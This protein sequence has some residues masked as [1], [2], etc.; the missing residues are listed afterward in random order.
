[1][2]PPKDFSLYFRKKYKK[3][4]KKEQKK[5]IQSVQLKDKDYRYK[6]DLPFEIPN[7]EKNNSKTFLMADNEAK[8]RILAND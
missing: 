6:Y 2:E 3:L 7:T 8:N 1:M 5:M 4:M